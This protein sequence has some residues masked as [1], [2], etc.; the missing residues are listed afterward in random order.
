MGKLAQA[1]QETSR[2][3][4][5]APPSCTEGSWETRWWRVLA[6]GPAGG[7]REDPRHHHQ[8]NQTA[9]HK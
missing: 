3:P 8:R 2:I 5:D 7:P 6:G 9:I 4:L 1:S